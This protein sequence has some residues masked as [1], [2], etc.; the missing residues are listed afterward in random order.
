[1]GGMEVP[2]IPP[3]P[4]H[5][6]SERSQSPNRDNF[7]RSPFNEPPVS[8]MI[9]GRKSGGMYSKSR[10]AS[11]S[12][13]SLPQ[14]PPSVSLPSVG[15]E[16][17]EYA[18]IEYGKADAD[19]KQETSP[20]EPA[21]TRN[22]AGDLP[23]HAP[24][25]SFSN[26]NA[27]ARVAAVTRTDSSQAAAVGIGK[28]PT[29][30]AA[31]DDTVPENRNLKAKV[32]FRTASSASTERPP[33]AQADDE[34]GIPEIGQRVPMYPDAGDVQAPS[35]SPYQQ[36]FPSGIGFHNAGMKAGKG[37]RRSQSRGEILP[38]GSYG[39]HG[40]GVPAADQFEKAWYEKHPDALQREEH[41]EYG[42]GIGGG[43]G[44][45]ALSSDDLNKLVRE[46]ASKQL[47]TSCST[48]RYAF[49]DTDMPSESQRYGAALPNEQMGYKE[50][51]EYASRLH[52]PQSATF[53]LSH[54]NSS[55]PH[56]ESPLRKASFPA[57]HSQGL[58]KTQSHDPSACRS[59]EH[60]LDSDVEDDE[61]YVPD[62]DR[63]GYD[64]ESVDSGY[65]VPILASDEVARTPGAEFMQPA[66]SP[67]QER[68]GSYHE[69]DYSGFKNGS[70][71]GS[72]GNSRPSS[73]PGSIYSLPGLSRFSTHDDDRENT[74]TPLED[75]D[76]YEPLF[77]DEEGN[78]VRKPITAAD[79]LKLREQ[80]KRFP[81]QDIWEDTP[82]SLQLQATV[83]TPE[84]VVEQSKSAPKAPSAVF[85]TPEQEAARKGEV[86][87]ED[88]AKLI[89][90][91]ERLAKSSFQPHIRDEM[92][93]HG[94]K[95]RFPS[96]DIWEDSPDSA[97]LTTTVGEGSSYTPKSPPDLGEEAGAV[98]TTS[99]AP[100]DGIISGDQPR[101][102]AT[103]GA[104]AMAKP[105][106][107][108]R[109]SKS[110]VPASSTDINTQPPIPARPPKRLHQVPPADAPTPVA[111]SKLSA[112][113]SPT[114]TRE[115]SSTDAPKGPTLPDRPKP[116]VPARPAKPT[117]PDAAD[118][119]PSSKAISTSSVGNEEQTDK[120]ITF[121]PG[122]P[123]P[124]PAVPARPAGGKIAQMKG[125]FL[126][127]LDSRLK[128]GP[129]GSKPQ[130]KVEPEVEEE[131][132]PLADARKGRAKGPVRRKPAPT[133]VAG[134]EG[135][136]AKSEAPKW[137]ISKPVTVWQTD[138]H[139]SINL[140]HGMEAA[141][142]SEPSAAEEPSKSAA[143]PA[144]SQTTD[145]ST[146]LKSMHQAKMA[147]GESLR[148][149]DPLSQE[150]VA[151]PGTTDLASPGIEKERNPLSIEPNTPVASNSPAT[152]VPSASTSDKVPGKHEERPSSIDPVSQALEEREAAIR[153]EG[154]DE[155][156][157]GV[158]VGGE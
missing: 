116:Q 144:P 32:S 88:K 47:G 58:H 153:A 125:G 73:R 55:Q 8:G 50:A 49:D 102:G 69:N 21:Q 65:D 2:T 35:P 87:E 56:V 131:K 121:Q 53:R 119:T 148:A 100:K 52:S 36:Q 81:S 33:S 23:L 120:G 7:P 3:R 76:E 28:A 92:D 118:S 157:G 101:D 140:V 17:N 66:V 124:K 110:K 1:M 74:H 104:P 82:N 94:L 93:R 96:R 62:K 83:D 128:L 139:G 114:D 132:A 155:E 98:V 79:R 15:Q 26:S 72:A 147:V 18:D 75:V 22:I 13:L 89:P 146:H 111:P 158:S 63:N 67:V 115:L 19:T 10:N 151:T 43:R 9:H 135:E 14:R 103:A 133:A 143:S 59:T 107:P 71:S 80:M 29:P 141:T 5:R 77:P 142:T 108:P 45:W 11:S 134:A 126:A 136:S 70:R 127:D 86:T 149:S 91:E 138:E 20:N 106:I 16:G 39:M 24:R 31:G 122:A 57:E 84:P 38:P 90:R 30:S 61:T 42:P 85:E 41:G 95:Q 129:Q 150:K 123:K 99:G 4:G 54:S 109:P 130:E 44:E 40:H 97:A 12:S 154:A 37:I 60:A 78:K 113:S 34:H 152:A 137:A 156:E 105:S 27:K 51:E 48:P 68:R 64:R 25:P 6:T 145:N 112:A 117:G 46:T